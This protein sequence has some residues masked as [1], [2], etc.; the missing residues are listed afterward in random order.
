MGSTPPSPSPLSSTSTP[1][2]L[3][4]LL[5]LHGGGS[6]SR[7]FR[8]QARRLE[9]LLRYRFRFVYP[10][11]TVPSKPGHAILP[12]FES[13]G[14]FVRW[15]EDAWPKDGNLGEWQGTPF[16]QVAEVDRVIAGAVKEAVGSGGGGDDEGDGGLGRVVGILGFSQG[17][18]LTAGLVCREYD[19]RRSTSSTT[20][21][22]TTTTT[23]PSPLAFPNL[24]FSVLIGAP[25]PPISLTPHPPTPPTPTSAS[26]SPSDPYDG[27][28]QIPTLHAW[29]HDDHVGD[30]CAKFARVCD[31][32]NCIVYKFNGEHHLPLTDAESEQLVED[33]EEVYYRGVSGTE[34]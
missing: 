17:A 10:N 7:I 1:T 4:I 13:V 34:G 16:E 12:V 26:S 6:N 28:R 11:A 32:K 33:L 14:P 25:Y 9:R 19:R 29:G 22:T 15:V 21:S 27:L 24:K 18:R 30:G 3:P 2:S 23:S 20:T 31:S 5:C 8:F